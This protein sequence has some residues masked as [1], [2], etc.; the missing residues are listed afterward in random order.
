MIEVDQAGG[1][2]RLIALYR[3]PADV[4]EFFEHY[5][6]IHTPLVKAIPHLRSLRIS[7]VTQSFVGEPGYF[8]MAEMGFE[9]SATFAQAMSSRENREAATDLQR[10][11]AGL[12]TLL[13]VAD[14]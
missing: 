8:L 5:D 12:V 4:A 2:V 1:A 7:R 9:N 14:R 6:K 10:F 11:A 3:K 13:V